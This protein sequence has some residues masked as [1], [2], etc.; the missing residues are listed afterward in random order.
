MPLF[1]LGQCQSQAWIKKEGD[2]NGLCYHTVSLICNCLTTGE[3]VKRQRQGRDLK[4]NFC[5]DQFIH[6]FI[7]DIYIAP[8]QVGLLISDPNPSGRIMLFYVE[9]ISGRIL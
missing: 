7:A 6:S 8:L 3:L 9:G 5:K 4:T 2:A 1:A